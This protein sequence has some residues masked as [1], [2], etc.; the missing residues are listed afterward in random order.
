MS[1]TVFF[2]QRLLQVTSHLFLQLLSCVTY[3]LFL[4]LLLQVTSHLFLQLLSCVTYDLFLQRLLQVTSHLFLQ[5]LSCVTYDLFLQRL[6][7]VTSHLFLQLLSC[8]TYDLFLQRLSLVTGRLFLQPLPC[9]TYGL[10]PAAI[11][12]ANKPSF[13]QPLPYAIIMGLSVQSCC[14]LSLLQHAILLTDSTSLLPKVKSGMGSPDRNVSM[15]DIHRRELLCLYCLRHAGVKGNE[16]ADRLAG[17]GTITSGLRLRR[18]DVL[19]SLRHCL[20]AQSQ[21]HHTIDHL[22]ERGMERG[23]ARRPSLK[24]RKR[25]IVNQ[26]NTG[27]VSKA[28]LGKLLRD[29]LERIWA[30]PKA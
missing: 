20:R 25:A 24:G 4:Q 8:V 30:F 22:E 12:I 11:I 5:L 9:V 26:T 18:S 7:Q 15:V 27:S 16:R 17:K 6:L 1:R 29:G 13:L 21:G 14:S 10:F 3:D 23:S 19:S 28:T 2:L